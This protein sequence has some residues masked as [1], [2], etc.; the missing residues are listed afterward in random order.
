MVHQS[1]N[2]RVNNL[3]SIYDF[4][5]YLKKKSIGVRFINIKFMCKN[6]V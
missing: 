5:G 6:L 1:L 2:Q 3:I 4:K